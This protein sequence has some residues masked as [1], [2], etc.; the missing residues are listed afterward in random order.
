MIISLKNGY[1]NTER[2]LLTFLKL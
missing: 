1:Q 2:V